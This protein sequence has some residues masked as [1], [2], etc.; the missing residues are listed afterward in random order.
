MLVT[1]PEYIST[2]YTFGTIRKALEMANMF[3]QM[4]KKATT[5]SPIM[6]G[7]EKISVAD[8]IAK[9]P[10]GV[11]VTGFDIVD[12]TSDD[13]PNSYPVLTFSEDTSKFIFGGTVMASIVNAWLAHFEG[14]IEA[15]NKA[16]ASYDGVKLKFSRARA[17]NGNREYTSIEVVE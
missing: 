9:Y 10:D 4:A 15:C 3:A 13:G 8:V 17:K 2:Y 7:R 12:S 16:L 6:E 5:L 14:D 1:R 11:T